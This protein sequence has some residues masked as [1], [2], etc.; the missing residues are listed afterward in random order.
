MKISCFISILVLLFS[1]SANAQNTFQKIYGG[2]DGC[3]AQQTA[4]GGFITA[5][6]FYDSVF[7]VK[8]DA[9]GNS[10]W[11]RSYSF[12]GSNVYMQVKYIQQ[13]PDQSFVV[14]GTTSINNSQTQGAFLMKLSS[15]GSVVWAQTDGAL[16][17]PYPT[18]VPAFTHT[19]DN[20]F[21]IAG[22]LLEFC[23]QGK[24]FG[25]LYKTDSIGKPMW[26]K[27]YTASISSPSDNI[28]ALIQTQDGGYLLAGAVLIKTNPKGDTLWTKKYGIPIR[29]VKQTADSGYI[30]AGGTPASLL[31]ITSTGMLS[32]AKTYGPSSTLINSVQQTLDGGYV[33]AGESVQLDSQ[34]DAFVVKTNS[35]GDTLWTKTYGGIGPDY[36]SSIASCAGQGLVMS[37]FTNQ[38]GIFLLRLDSLG[39]SSCSA[40]K[41][42]LAAVSISP[43][44]AAASHDTLSRNSFSPLSLQTK[45]TQYNKSTNFCFST[46][47]QERNSAFDMQLFPNPSSGLVELHLTNFNAGKIKLSVINI[48]GEI[49]FTETVTETN[50][51]NNWEKSLDLQVLPNGVYFLHIEYAGQLSSGKLIIVK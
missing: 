36:A 46:D 44:I 2:K 25:Y 33:L 39:T 35:T 29:S 10:S 22:E 41:N 51:F 26:M 19:S 34:G 38:G 16:C 6:T 24:S 37:G 3:C 20:G 14:G 45:S 9:Q 48:L 49:R 8:T 5:G 13:M 15:Q 17:I 28:Q 4:D 43:S 47:I 21:A 30:L 18:N 50:A 40:L 7:V 12:L 23:S 32:W 1:S 42:A 27:T 11:T 31:K